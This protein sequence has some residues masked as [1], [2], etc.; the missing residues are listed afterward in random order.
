MGM[1]LSKKNSQQMVH[2][3][4]LVHQRYEHT[5]KRNIRSFIDKVWR[6]KRVFR[7]NGGIYYRNIEFYIHKFLGTL[8]EQESSEI[9]P[10]EFDESV[11]LVSQVSIIE[12]TIRRSP[13]SEI[14]NRSRSRSSKPIFQDSKAPGAL[15]LDDMEGIIEL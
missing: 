6:P 8:N 14:I 10:T 12:D 4:A 5:K 13:N 15:P 11:F 7:F 9:G 1:T 2:S 3:K